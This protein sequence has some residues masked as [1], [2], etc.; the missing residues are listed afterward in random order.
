MQQRI[1]RF[2]LRRVLL[3]E[4]TALDLDA[5]QCI[6][7]FTLRRVLLESAPLLISMQ[8]SVIGLDFTRDDRPMVTRHDRTVFT[9]HRRPVVTTVA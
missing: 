9:R 7:R 4:R 3:A 6:L 8:L 5:Q 1:Q 2:T